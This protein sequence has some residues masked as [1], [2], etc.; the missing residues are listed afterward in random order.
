MPDA[1]CITV[2]KLMNTILF[3][4]QAGMFDISYLTNIDL[5][6]ERCQKFLRYLLANDLGKLKRG[7]YPNTLGVGC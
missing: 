4:L 6:G 3:A 5:H 1:H 2:L 7:T